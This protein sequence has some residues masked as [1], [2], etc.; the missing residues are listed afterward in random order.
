MIKSFRSDE[1]EKLFQRKRSPRFLPDVHRVALRKLLLL[2]AA[3]RL[4]DLRMPPGNRLEKLGG[5]RRGQHSIRIND[6]WRI[7]FRWS[8]GNACDV[9]IADYH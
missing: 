2:D 9:E 7:C 6:Q 1:T 3:E 4:E 5:G 8:E